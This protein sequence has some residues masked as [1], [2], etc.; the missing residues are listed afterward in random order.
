MIAINTEERRKVRSFKSVTSWNTNEFMLPTFGQ[1]ALQLHALGVSSV[2][3]HGVGATTLI[4][5]YHPDTA[6]VMASRY[7]IQQ[8]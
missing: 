7:S 1:L 6:F 2:T 4:S 3:I 8:K 5:S